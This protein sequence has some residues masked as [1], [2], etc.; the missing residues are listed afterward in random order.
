MGTD[1][2]D[3]LQADAKQVEIDVDKVRRNHKE[4]RGQIIRTDSKLQV[5][6]IGSLQAAPPTHPSTFPADFLS[7][8]LRERSRMDVCTAHRWPL[9]VCIWTPQRLSGCRNM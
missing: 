6:R 3:Y 7:F 5:K 8:L 2:E 1:I 4:T 9:L